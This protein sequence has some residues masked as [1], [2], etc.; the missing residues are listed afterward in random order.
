MPRAR[1]CSCFWNTRRP[2]TDSDQ[3]ELKDGLVASPEKGKPQ[4][5]W[6]IRAGDASRA[7]CNPATVASIST[8]VRMLKT[9]CSS[10]S[11]CAT[12][13]CYG[14]VGDAVSAQRRTLVIRKTGRWLPL[15]SV[16]GVPNLIERTGT[17]LPNAEGYFPSL[18]FGMTTGATPI[19]AW[20]CSNR[21]R[22]YFFLQKIQKRL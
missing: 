19:D 9:L 5:K 20:L 22:R 7:R 17:A 18:E 6:I 12:T 4:T 3:I 13:K 8:R 15:T 21:R 2:K 14:S 10:S 1:P 16:Q 11:R